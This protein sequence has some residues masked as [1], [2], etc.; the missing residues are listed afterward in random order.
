M[1]LLSTFPKDALLSKAWSIAFHIN[2][3]DIENILILKIQVILTFSEVYHWVKR[4]IFLS[5]TPQQQKF[6]KALVFSKQFWDLDRKCSFFSL[7]PGFGIHA[8]IEAYVFL[9][10]ATTELVPSIVG[11]FEFHCLVPGHVHFPRSRGWAKGS[12]SLLTRHNQ[13]IS[14]H[15]N[16]QMSVHTRPDTQQTDKGNLKLMNQCCLFYVQSTL[17]FSVFFCFIFLNG[18]IS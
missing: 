6:W 2:N 11:A 14:C 4:S 1:S 13:S 10:T 7:G 17:I 15:Y 8:S 5:Q 3:V 12:Q 18:W 16:D 9:F